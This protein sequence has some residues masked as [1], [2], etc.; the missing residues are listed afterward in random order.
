[1]NAAE[2][3]STT[4]VPMENSY[5]D[6]DLPIEERVEDLLYRMTLEEKIEQLSGTPDCDKM[7]SNS[8]G[9][10]GIP[11]LQ[12]ADG[13]HGVRWGKATAFPVPIAIASSWEPELMERIGIAIGK[14]IKAKGRNHSLGPC[15]NICKDPR[16]GR[17]YEGYGEDPYL[18]SKM[19]V[20]A[21]KGIQSQKV[22]ATPKHFA[23][24][25]MERDR[26]S[27]SVE[28][29]ERTLR[30]IYLPAFK[31]CIKEGN[32]WSIMSAYNKINGIYCSEHKHLLRDILKGEWEF[33]GFVLSDWGACHSTV[34]SMN[35]GFD[36]EMPNN[37]YYGTALLKAVKEGLVSEEIINDSVR[38]ILRAKFWAGLFD[39]SS[40]SSLDEQEKVNP[41]IVE[42]PEHIELALEAA[43][44]SIVL[45]KNENDLLPL[46]RNK[47]KSIAV[48]GP[49][50][51][52]STAGINLGSS[53][54][55]P[56][57][58]VTPLE[59]IK[60]KVGDEIII[61]DKPEK[62]DLCI[63]FAGLTETIAGRVEGEGIDRDDLSLPGKQ[64]DLI[65]Q[66]SGINKNTVVVLIGG[67]AV[68]MNEWID[69]VP[70]IVQTWYSGQEGGNAIADVLFGDYNPGGKLPITFPKSV[71]QLPPLSWNYKEDYKIGIGYRYYDKQN[72]KPLFPFG[73]GLSYT[74]FKYSA[75]K[76]KSE[77]SGIKIN[78]SVEVE[79][80]GNREGDEV[81]QLYLRD[82]ESSIERPVQELKRF[83]RITLKPGEKKEVKFVLTSEDLAFYNKDMKFIVQPGTFEVMIGSSSRDIH[84]VGSFII[85]PR[86]IEQLNYLLG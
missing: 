27:G 28:I 55:H 4:E 44:K 79:N 19:A 67:S 41:N 26:K 56:S 40:T 64:N 1:M 77:K 71:N 30:E 7:A 72:I 39:E 14:E 81:V 43:R 13:P 38:R 32:A 15:L 16:G 8:N 83:K 50:A 31:S 75:L 63:V 84:L 45:L 37:D 2:N 85:L 80:I 48:L 42:C 36:L 3:I 76:I 21:I 73:H 47:I 86:E 12:F 54:V 65:K 6:S 51:C 25:N 9:R 10:L 20:S 58:V 29:D 53:Q 66:M 24:N 17:T 70:A 46:D 59:G 61:T 49:S 23:C 78:I 57:Y 62:A 34:E 52:V 35:A 33:K 11:S 68:T 82:V 5:L 18:T 69:T 22:I 60:N 74:K